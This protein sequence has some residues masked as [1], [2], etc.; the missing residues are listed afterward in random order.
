MN[1][2]DNWTARKHNAFVDTVRW[3]SRIIIIIVIIIIII[4]NLRCVY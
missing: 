4:M 1:E 3:H 2:Q